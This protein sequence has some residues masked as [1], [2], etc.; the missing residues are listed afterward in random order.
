MYKLNFSINIFAQLL[1]V[2]TLVLITPF[3]VKNIG[4]DNYGKFIY[5][6]TFFSILFLFRSF[7]TTFFK[8]ISFKKGYNWFMTAF[9]SLFLIFLFLIVFSTFSIPH[10]ELFIILLSG[11]L[12]FMLTAFYIHKH[13]NAVPNL[14]LPFIN[15]FLY[16]Y[17]LNINQYDALNNIHVLSIITALIIFIFSIY[18]FFDTGINFKYSFT[19]RYQRYFFKRS[20]QTVYFSM[21]T[22]L[23]TN[24]EKIVLPILGSFE[25][26]GIYNLLILLPSRLISIYS[27]FSNVFLKET[28]SKNREKV[29][30]AVNNYFF[31]S[32]SMFLF[33]TAFIII[34]HE[35]IILYFMHKNCLEYTVVFFVAILISFIQIFGFISFNLLSSINKLIIF[36]SNNLKSALLLIFLLG[37]LSLFSY[38]N[39]YTI[40]LG[41]LL[42]K[43]YEIVNAN[44]IN[45]KMS[46]NIINIFIYQSRRF[47]VPFFIS[48]SIGLYFV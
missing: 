30:Y 1:N 24:V 41:V 27:N 21:V 25:L 22:A 46:I 39:L 13:L 10:I 12:Y 48:I 45:S 4:I 40:V 18:L 7:S 11:I 31:Y 9:Y 38:L 47:L 28:Y 15:L 14:I 17:Y 42:S 2:F 32:I 26:L 6:Y 34:F 19:G 36:S 5:I 33:V 29:L 20:I 35:Q 16:T 3:V 8:I 23:Q 43:W 44:Y 37:T